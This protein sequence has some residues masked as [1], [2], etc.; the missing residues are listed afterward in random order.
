MSSAR[1]PGKVLADIGGQPLLGHLIARLQTVNDGYPVIIA[2][3]A[4]VDDDP[5]AE[6][7][8]KQ[9]VDVFRGSLKDTVQ[10]A[11]DCA[12]GFGFDHFVRICGDSPFAD[13]STI[14][15][16]LERHREESADV[17]TNVHPRSFPIGLSVEIIELKALEKLASQSSDRE[18][19]EHLTRY[20]YR[21]LTNFK[22]A[23]ITCPLGNFS[24]LR[25]AV[26]TSEDLA[27]ARWIAK[28]AG[29]PTNEISLGMVID[30]AREHDASSRK[31]IA[32]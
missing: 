25:L 1:L 20:F 10:R 13:P 12:R 6:F 23:N 3:S 22:V 16:L 31:G 27:R 21:N 9:G 11:I 15:S 2:T 26:D 5:I 4:Q 17:T 24:T 18:D 32:S 14:R 30:L 7:A 8:V 29:V 28:H 19:R